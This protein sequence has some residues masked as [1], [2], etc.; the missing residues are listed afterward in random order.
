MI[1]ERYLLKSKV[2]PIETKQ[3]KIFITVYKCG[4][5]TKASELLSTS[6][7][8]ISEQIKNLESTLC[9]KLFDRLGQSIRPTRKAEILYQKAHSIIDD[10]Q[11]L[12]EQLATEDQ[13][14]TGELIIGASNTPGVYILPRIAA[15]FKAVKLQCTSY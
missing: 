4:S 6:Q 8:T 2:I 10:I 9:C 15:D 13:T 7:P 3:L 5:F 1:A 12:K 14:V 11:Q